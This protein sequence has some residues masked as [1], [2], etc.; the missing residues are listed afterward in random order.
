MNKGMTKLAFVAALVMALSAVVGCG[1]SKHESGDNDVYFNG[2]V[3]DGVTGARL[4]DYEITVR[5]RN[6]TIK[7]TV[8]ETGRYTIGPFTTW[9]DFTVEIVAANYR[10]FLSHNSRVDLPESFEGSDSVGLFDTSQTYFVDA[11]LFPSGLNSP[12]TVIEVFAS[13]DDELRPSGRIRIRAI[14]ISSLLDSEVLEFNDG[15]GGPT[16]TYAGPGFFPGVSGQW[17]S[18]DEDLQTGVI[19]AELTDGLFTIAEGQLPYGVPFRVDIHSVDGYSPEVAE[20][21]A[22]F[23]KYLAITISPQSDRPIELVSENSGDC[24]PP[25]LVDDDAN[26]TPDQ[27]TAASAQIVLTFDADVELVTDQ[28]TA[29]N[30]LD[31]GLDIHSPDGI[32]DDFFGN[33]LYFEF[34]NDRGVSIA[35]SGT[36]LTISW[37]PTEATFNDSNNIVDFD[38]PI[39]GVIYTGFDEISVK[40][41]NSP[42]SPAITLDE[43]LGELLSDDYQGELVCGTQE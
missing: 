8:D 39:L 20:L 1:T 7:G 15:D 5:Y 14:D 25:T 40:R 6:K 27:P 23:Q 34:D 22:G 26:G 29:N 3:Y 11:V 9:Q 19:D 32:D 35:A 33:D 42:G 12:E 16:Y 24:T 41:A 10:T 31:S 37:I 18:N 21:L 28:D 17:W 4:T 13:G 2:Y 43:L 36:T 30:S 38:D